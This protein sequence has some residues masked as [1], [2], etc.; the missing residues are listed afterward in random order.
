MKKTIRLT[1]SDLTRIIKHI[2][3][4]QSQG[5]SEFIQ[6]VVE[7][8]HISDE[9]K[10][11]IIST[12]KNSECKNITFEPMRMGEGLSLGD[13]LVIN[14]STLNYSLGR[15][16]F[17][18]FHEMAHQYQFKKYG[19]EKMLELYN[20]EIDIKDAAKFMMSVENVADEFAV[21]KMNN[22]QRRGLI[23]LIP[24]DTRK[25]YDRVTLG[26]LEQMI[27]MF[28]NQLSMNNIRGS[29]NISEFLYNMVIINQ[30]RN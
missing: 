10:N 11:E 20:N 29:K 1:E 25:G 14:P 19:Q 13:R 24:S 30:G 6:R 5:E 22:I 15:F 21:R 7:R 2:V 18:L 16:L 28:R 26:M 12:I 3:N 4:E 17:I 9:I 23:E 27:S 8:Y